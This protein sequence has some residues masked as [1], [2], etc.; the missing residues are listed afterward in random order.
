MRSSGSIRKAIFITVVTLCPLMSWQDDF[1][2]FNFEQ[3]ATLRRES[4]TTGNFGTLQLTRLGK[5]P[6]VLDGGIVARISFRFPGKS[7]SPVAQKG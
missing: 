1:I 7:A 2:Y 6:M 5:F 4:D 3:L